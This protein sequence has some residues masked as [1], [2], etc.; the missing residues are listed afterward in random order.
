MVTVTSMAKRLKR[1]LGAAAAAGI[2]IRVV[3]I[4]LM[5][6]WDDVVYQYKKSIK[7]A[8][9]VVKPIPADQRPTVVVLGTGWGALSFIRHLDH[10]AVNVK[11]CSSVAY[12]SSVVQL[13]SSFIYYLRS[14]AYLCSLTFYFHRSF[15]L[16]LSSST[17][18][19]WL[20]RQQAP[21]ATAPSWNLSDGTATTLIMLIAL[22][23]LLLVVVAWPQQ[24]SN[25]SK[26]S[27]YPSTSKARRCV[28]ARMRPPTHPHLT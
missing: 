8:L 22:L 19:C 23:V 24:A 21:L 4:T 2:T 9:G 1:I 6:G 13:H 16:G 18:L 14:L 20:A 15:L 27:V 10:D 17:P 25:T 5:D 28:A 3:H 12:A 7:M 11:V 26:R